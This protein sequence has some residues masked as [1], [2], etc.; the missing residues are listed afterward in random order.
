MLKEYHP[1]YNFYFS[2]KRYVCGNLSKLMIACALRLPAWMLYK[3]FITEWNDFPWTLGKD[4]W[5][6]E[7]FLLTIFSAFTA[8]S[9]CT[10][11]TSNRQQKSEA[12]DV[13]LK[14]GINTIKTAPAA[15]LT[16]Y[17]MQLSDT[18]PPDAS[19]V[20]L[21]CRMLMQKALIIKVKYD[22]FDT[23]TKSISLYFSVL[24]AEP[25]PP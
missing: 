11:S 14:S 24:W 23:S 18:D 1:Q 13:V 2:M 7:N 3:I 25:G 16:L 17:I 21:R 5:L 10:A 20:C 19:I 4:S 8:L 9:A 22:I 12:S 6:P 15:S